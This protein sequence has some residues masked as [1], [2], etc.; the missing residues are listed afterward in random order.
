MTDYLFLDIVLAA[1]F[2]YATL[3]Y[4][5]SIVDELKTKKFEL[6]RYYEENG[7]VEIVDTIEAKKMEQAIMEHIHTVDKDYT[8]FTYSVH[9]EHNEYKMYYTFTI[10]DEIYHYVML[11]D[12]SKKR[13]NE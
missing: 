11:Q 8:M 2:I 3:W 1:I 5:N 10:D 12:T 7:Q 6:Y 9:T 4:I 13:S